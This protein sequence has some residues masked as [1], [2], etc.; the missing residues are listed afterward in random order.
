[1]EIPARTSNM[2]VKNHCKKYF[3]GRNVFE[4]PDET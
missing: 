1:M 3:L 4:I 2:S